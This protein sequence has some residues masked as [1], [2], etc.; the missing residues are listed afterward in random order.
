MTQKTP[1]PA[2]KPMRRTPI[3]LRVVLLVSLA[4]NL[5]VV[6]VVAGH[7][8]RD[9]PKGRVPRVD[10]MQAPMT[11]ALSH[12]D[13]RAIG[14][15][16]RQEYRDNRPSREEVVAEY[17]GVIAALRAD[18]FQPELVEDAFR[19]QRAAASSRV[20]IGQKLLMDR[21]TAMSADERHAFADRLEEGLRRGPRHGDKPE[22]DRD[23][24]R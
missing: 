7:F 20:E 22:G 23:D 16:L 9:D 3:W 6:G 14:K 10:R 15:A 2:P 18:P 11:F 5:L 21:L 24:D 19:R 8:L 4:L 12:E 17:Q 1:N 13:R